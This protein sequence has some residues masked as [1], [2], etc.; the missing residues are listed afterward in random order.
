MSKSFILCLVTLSL[1][2]GGPC[3]NLLLNSEKLPV[4]EARAPNFPILALYSNIEG[5]VT[6]QV[7]VGQKGEV[8]RAEY[9]SG[10][11]LLSDESINAA[12]EWKF[13]KNETIGKLFFEY[14]ILPKQREGIANNQTI[15]FFPPDRV[16]ISCVTP[17]PVEE[18]LTNPD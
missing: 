17:L 2:G 15:I 11:K 4:K 10:P 3:L 5:T 8:V 7:A 9:I 1:I 6:I 18:S 16:R 12:K 13:E 14:K